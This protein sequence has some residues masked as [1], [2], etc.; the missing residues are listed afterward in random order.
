MKNNFTR[1]PDADPRACFNQST[2]SPAINMQQPPLGTSHLI[3]GDSLVRV[4]QNLR[5]TCITTVMAFGGTT[6]AQL[7]HM[8][9][10]MNPGRIPNIM[11]LIG[12]NNVSRDS[13]EEEAQWKSMMSR[14]FTT[15]WQK[16]KCAVLTVCTVPM[17]TRTL[18]STGRRH[19]EGVIRWNNI[20]RNLAIRNAGRMIL[21][22]IEHELR[23]MDQARLT[24]DGI[25]FDSIEGQAW[26]NRVFQKRLDEM[27]V[28]L[29]DARVLKTEETTNE[30]AISTIVPRNTSGNGPSRDLQAAKL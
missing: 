23:A 20:L 13:D 9:E 29:F 30:P 12:T 14:L 16:F 28:E 1:V 21:M 8:V 6:I 4:L 24:T 7:F 10:L 5:T 2:W 17:S 25:H 26:M 19:N 15:L 22:D 18:T 27:E 11:I 3:M